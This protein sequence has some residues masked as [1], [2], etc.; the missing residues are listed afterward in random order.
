MNRI[1]KFALSI[2]LS[3]LTTPITAKTQLEKATFAGG[4]FWCMEPPFEK[5]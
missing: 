4:C 5:T 1:T 3:T 2:I